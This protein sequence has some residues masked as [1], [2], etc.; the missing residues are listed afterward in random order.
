MIEFFKN[1]T[2]SDYFS[3]KIAFF[4]TTGKHYF[5]KYF[6]INILFINIL[7]VLTNFKLKIYFETLFLS[8]NNSYKNENQFINYFDENIYLF[9]SILIFFFLLSVIFLSLL[10]ICYS[11]IYY[12][13]TK[14][15]GIM[16]FVND[17]IGAL[18]H[19]IVR[20]F[21]F[22]TYAIFILVPICAAC[23]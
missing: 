12:Q 5:K 2:F 13:S 19:N 7:V 17:L 18:K 20:Q 8:F 23:F 22:F 9:F 6:I 21:I 14:K 15:N 4:K 16:F 3:D 10:N 11:V 1:R